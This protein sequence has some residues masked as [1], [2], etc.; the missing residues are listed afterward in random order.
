MVGAASF[1]SHHRHS[2]QVT[3]TPQKQS[4]PPAPGGQFYVSS[5]ARQTRARFFPLSSFSQDNEPNL[6]FILAPLESNKRVFDSLD[7]RQGVIRRALYTKMKEK[8]EGATKRRQKER[9]GERAET[10]G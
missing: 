8:R 4:P 3:Q 5:L 10:K 2:T 6:C 7:L 9:R 1:V